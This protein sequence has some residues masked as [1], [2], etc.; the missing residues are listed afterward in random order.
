MGKI[1]NMCYY[2]TVPGIGEVKYDSVAKF[3]SVQ[4]FS[5]QIV[6]F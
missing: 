2:A 5:F 4:Y 1:G 3:Y 6:D